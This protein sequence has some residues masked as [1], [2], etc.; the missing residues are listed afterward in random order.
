MK[1]KNGFKLNEEEVDEF[2]KKIKSSDI[3]KSR[4]V[5]FKITLT[6]MFVGILWIVYSDKLLNMMITNKDIVN[7]IQT[8]KGVIYVFL[9]A[10]LIYLLMVKSFEKIRYLSKESIS[11][12]EELEAAY[13]ELNAMQYA[14]QDQYDEIQKSNEALKKSKERYKYRANHDYITGLYSIIKFKDMVNRHI[15]D[16]KYNE[17]FIIVYIDIDNFKKIN[18]IMGH[19]LGDLFLRNIANEFRKR[20]PKNAHICRM[21]G[22]EFIML[23]PDISDFN[24]I[25]IT[26]KAF[27]EKFKKNW[28]IQDRNFYVTL[29]VGISMYPEHGKNYDS[30]LKNADIAMYEV[31]NTTKNSFYIYN[32]KLNLN[33]L[34][35]LEIEELLR[36]GIKNKEFYLKYQPKINLKDA[37]IAGFEVLVRWDNNVRGFVSPAEFI[38]VAEKTGLIIQISDFIFEKA[39][40]TLHKWNTLYSFKQSLSINLSVV[41]FQDGKLLEKIDYFIEKYSL[42]PKYIEFEITETL[43]M[44]NFEYIND[45]LGEFRKRGIKISLD[46]FGKGYSSL[47]YLKELEIDIVKIDKAFIDG[48]LTNNKE[49]YIVKAVIDMAHSMG[50][51]VVAEGI[52]SLEQLEFLQLNACNKAQGYLF[53]KPLLENEA[54]RLL[55]DGKVFR[56]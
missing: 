49:K 7:K 14:L 1:H 25:D 54:R 34:N 27:L 23:I 52:E 44:E 48:L 28:S 50:L 5:E 42:D 29:S 11:R 38:P 20:A 55:E 24:E 2:L 53:S 40:E 37:K 19:E 12:Y 32:E 10:L 56:Y 30:L 46:D 26:M 17:K 36:E 41:Q 16:I 6:Y 51:S 31:K 33:M 47:N 43:V 4:F 3:Y 45:I 13:E 21:G 22:D 9:T 39:F 35:L 18:D 15:K 8:I